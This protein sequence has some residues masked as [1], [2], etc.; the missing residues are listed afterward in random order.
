MQAKSDKP[1][2]M[3]RKLKLKYSLDP[4][5]FTAVPCDWLHKGQPV[6]TCLVL[7]DGRLMIC[8]AS[9][10]LKKM[11]ESFSFWKPFA[12]TDYMTNEPIIKA[13]T[14]PIKYENA[15]WFTKQV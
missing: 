2:I 8:L 1:D 10:E 5:R 7:K 9:G 3:F 4:N 13:I 14:V 15:V 12:I 11:G 6:Y